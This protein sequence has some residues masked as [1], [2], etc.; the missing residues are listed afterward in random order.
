[1][2]Q[3][4]NLLKHTFYTVFIFIASLT[5]AFGQKQPGIPQ[6][7]G[8]VDLSDTSNLIIFIVLP[9]IVIIAYFF[10]RSAVKKRNRKREE[11]NKPL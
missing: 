8:P 4:K 3:P 6:P 1:M 10:W 11:E 9:I 2:C 7:R 5:V